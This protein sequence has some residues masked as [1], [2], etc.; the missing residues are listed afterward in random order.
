MLEGMS[1][2]PEERTPEASAVPGASPPSVGTVVAGIYYALVLI[3]SYG[4]VATASVLVLASDTREPSAA[5]HVARVVCTLL[6]VVVP[7]GLIVH[8][9]MRIR[10][11]AAMNAL[12]DLYA[13]LV[14]IVMPVWGMFINHSISGECVRSGCDTG[15][16]GEIRALSEP[17]IVIMAGLQLVVALAYLVSRRRPEALHP[18]AEPWIHA[19]LLAGIV[20]HVAI[21]VHFGG[22]LVAGAVLFPF[23]G[24]AVAPVLTVVLLAVE[25]VRRLRRRG[26]EAAQPPPVQV[27]DPFR[28]GPELHAAPAAPRLDTRLL[29]GSA[30]R[31][32]VILGVYAVVAALIQ[33]DKYGAVAV[34]TQ[35]CG[36][37]FSKL[38]LEH[39]PAPNDCHY[40][41]TVAARGHMW[42]A[43]PER[44][45][46]RHGVPIVVNRQLAVANAFE[47]LL[48]ERWPRFGAF[49]RRTY[50]KLGY[51][52]SKHIRGPWL[53]DAVLL[54]MK[55]LEWAFYLTLLVVDLRSPEAR[56]SRMY[57]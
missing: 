33:H 43:R 16:P 22:D 17:A 21:G 20:L 4:S 32:P 56:I 35:T 19:A 47:D 5:W 48:H 10:R 49:A 3:A 55:P 52:V 27:M 6:G 18:Q 50:D 26:Q 39:L 9:V 14:L 40:L 45:G 8:L 29:A 13:F 57:R 44:I 41:C 12:R 25:L 51:P 31:V 15:G 24:A 34:F 36:H 53:A 1:Q 11:K 7:L 23:G 42:L 28:G 54:L 37:T 46:V 38:Q 2:A 30:A